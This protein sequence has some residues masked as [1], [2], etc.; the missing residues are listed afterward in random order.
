VAA[1]L[2]LLYA[3]PVARLVRLTIDDILDHDG[4]IFIRLGDPPAPVPDPFAAMLT[5]PGANRANMNT[6]NPACF[7][8]FPGGRAG[9]PLP[10][11]TSR[12]VY[13]WAAYSGRAGHRDGP[14]PFGRQIRRRAIRRS[15]GQSDGNIPTARAE[16]AAGRQG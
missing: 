13:G 14:V 5:E 11:A 8:L 9:Q 16:R 12:R 10:A 1:C 2:L 15:R 7:W 3:R 4:Q 6:A